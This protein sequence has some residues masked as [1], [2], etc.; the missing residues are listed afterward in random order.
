MKYRDRLRN[1]ERQ[2][3][4]DPTEAEE[5]WRKRVAEREPYGR[6]LIVELSYLSQFYPEDSGFRAP[7]GTIFPT[8]EEYQAALRILHPEKYVG[9]S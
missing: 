3:P 5:F 9:T 7:P 4:P 2:L 1:L 6:A 8:E